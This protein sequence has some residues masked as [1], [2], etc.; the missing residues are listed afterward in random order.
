MPF[1]VDTLVL[2][3][4]IAVAE[5]G[6]FSRAAALV[7]R[8]Q[9]AVS[10]QIKKLEEGVRCSLFTRGARDVALTEE[11]EIFLGYARRMIDLQWEA[12]S[13][14]NEPDVRGRITLGTPEDFATHYLPRILARFAQQHPHVQLDVTCDLTLNLL[15][16]FD[17]GK[18]DIVLLKR[19]PEKVRG[20]TKVWREPLVWAAAEH[21]EMRSPLPLVVSPQPCIYRA[22][23]VAALDR[24]RKPWQIVY[25]SPSLAGTVAAVRAGLGVTI[26]PGTMVP[27][28]L[29]PLRG[30]ARLPRLADSEIALMKREKLSPAGEVLAAHIISSLG[31]APG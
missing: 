24:A 10:L 12:F 31:G 16:A 19:D 17:R 29:R 26:L 9:S 14:L 8:T 23:A 1:H 21:Y 18:L 28:G 15:G 11:G 7:G 3:S 6:S 20:G 22:R 27:D 2:K 4:F 25:T 5:T 30:A 13:R